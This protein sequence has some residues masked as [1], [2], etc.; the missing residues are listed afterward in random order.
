MRIT[1]LGTSHGDHTYCRF[2]SATLIEIGDRLYL[3]DAGEPVT[4]LLIRAGQ[5]IERLRAVFITHMHADHAGGLSNLIAD[6][7]KRTPD[8]GRTTVLLPDA[9][10]VAPLDAWLKAQYVNWPAPRVSVQ[11]VRQGAVYDDGWARV[12]AVPTGHLERPDGPICFAYQLE[13]EGKRLLFTGDLRADFSDFP[14]VARSQPFDLC[15]CEMTHFE[16]AAALPILGRCPIG[17]LV[18]SHIHNPWHGR[19]EE[20]LKRIFT[21]LPYPFH[22]AHDGDV[23]EL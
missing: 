18:F 3:I 4:A 11:V 20:T 17:R 23:F 2:N 1:T 16:P 5:P 15:V 8:D 9:D 13:A 6:M 21:E 14:S 22:V 7:I 12:C 19:G 10:A